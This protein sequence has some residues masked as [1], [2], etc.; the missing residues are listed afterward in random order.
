[1]Y[2]LRAE[3]L[4]KLFS[5]TI[6]VAATILTGQLASAQE[7]PSTG[8]VMEEVV[9]TTARQREEVLQD[10]PA[11]VTAIT[12]DTLEAAAVERAADFVRL[13]PGVSLVQTAEVADSQINI[14]GI[15]GARDAENSF[16]LIVDGVL[17][18]NPASFNREYSDLQQIEILKGPQGAIYGRNAA[19]GA[20]I[21]TTRKPG[22]EYAGSIK[23]GAGEDST[24]TG[25]FS[26]G[27]PLTDAA[28][29]KLSGDYR[30]S[31]G[32]YTNVFLREDAVDDFRGWNVNGRLVFEPSD[33][34]TLD[35][36]AHVG[37]VDAASISF[38]AAFALPRVAAAF[39]A[40]AFFENPNEH[41]FQFN[42][43]VD[44][45]NR[46][47]SMDLSFKWDRDVAIGRLTAWALYSDV[48]NAFTADGT[49]GAFGFFFAEPTCIASW[50]QVFNSMFPLGPPQVLF[51][52]TPAAGG[53][54]GPYTPTTCD[55]TQYQE[56]N[57]RDYS[58][59]LRLASPGD[60][61][62]RWLTGIYYLNI[63]RQVGVNTGVDND[64]GRVTQRLFVPRTQRNSTEALVWDDFDS[65]VYA[66]F[67]N[68]AFDMT[69]AVELALALR[70]DRE[71]R[72]VSSLVP[73][74]TGPCTQLSQPCSTFIDA[75]GPLGGFTGNTPLNPA[76]FGGGVI[77]DRERTF[78]Q[79]QPK[80]SLSWEA[81]DQWTWYANW[82]IGFKSGGFN[83]QGSRATVDTYINSITG[84]TVS[85]RDE[86]EKEKSSASE[87]GFKASLWDR[88]VQLEAAVYNT[89]IDDLQFFEFLVGA[90]GLLRVVNNVDE[91]NVKGFELGANARI[92]DELRFVAGYS[93]VD[94]EIEANSSRPVT[95]GN[96]SP[97]TPDYTATAG[98]E[99]DSP[100]GGG[101]WRVQASAYW[102]LVGPTWFHTIQDETNQT[103][104]AAALGAFLGLADYSQM[105]RDRYQTIDAR[106]AFASD[107]WTFALVGK[108]IT[109]EEYLQEV[110][111]APEFGGAFI[112]PS[113][114]S[115]WAL[116]V[117]Y[118][119]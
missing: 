50:G 42:P 87:V 75:D 111:V 5:L 60:Q 64:N 3:K 112:H 46:Q 1:M 95:V 88:R 74:P 91:V 73:R 41:P 45:S 9:V 92:T 103:L 117:G 113:A 30:E 93:R 49:S 100:V 48:E 54:L 63:D 21:V 94:S 83:N 40:P 15:N 77:P 59:E 38:N 107:N 71:E 51:G 102:N 65:D 13:T 97:A 86:F 57:Q 6:A 69:D 68:I 62:L 110:I 31:D 32:F 52:P 35:I 29:W 101:G 89:D 20:I 99:L 16:A 119:F 82:G 11:T 36:K 98:L 108:N 66:V 18:T 4:S 72:A 47:D 17:Q 104:N 79:V 10:V 19:A 25:E 115:R 78:S 96:K 81:S 22:D 80:V 14:R 8:E 44:P 7:T 90:F 105:Q 53:I 85:I 109:D 24:Y 76:L 84:N 67:G 23:M 34:S 58:F 33:G 37:R 26:V 12:S 70:Y 56:R 106:L 43:N 114:L 28:G 55:G 61:R 2:S 116:E 39:G 27:G 118:R